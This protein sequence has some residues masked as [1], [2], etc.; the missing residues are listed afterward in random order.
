MTRSVNEAT[1]GV[2]RDE[3]DGQFFVFVQLFEDFHDLGAGVGI[4]VAGRFVGE[5]DAWFV[6]ERPGDGDALLLAAGHLGR[7][8][9][10]AIVE[11][12]SAQGGDGGVSAP[13]RG[14]GGIDHGQL[15]VFQRGAAGEQ[16]EVLEDE[17]DV[18]VSQG[19]ELISAEGVGGLAVYSEGPAG[20]H[21]ECP[22]NI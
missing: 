12:D 3:H 20:G 21:V 13:P 14:H 11:S 2:V 8:V 1:T 16:V 19:G 18:G 9:V 7:D 10:H 4:E 17:A 6:D 15:D 5:E 22:E